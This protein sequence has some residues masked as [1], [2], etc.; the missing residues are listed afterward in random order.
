MLYR[1]FLF[2]IFDL[3]L[4]S[5]DA[6]GNANKLL[7]RF[8]VLLIIISISLAWHAVEFAQGHVPLVVQ[9]ALAWQCEHCLI[10]TTMRVIGLFAV[11]SWDLILSDHRNVRVLVPLPVPVRTC[12]WRRRLPWLTRL[13]L[14]FFWCMPPPV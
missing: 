8:T 4:L 1:E 2:R 13:E 11:L 7:E 10:A 14:R 3:E 5:A 6:L 9:L 12:Y